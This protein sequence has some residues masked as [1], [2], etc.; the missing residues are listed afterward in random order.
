VDFQDLGN[1]LKRVKALSQ[2]TSL[3]PPAFRP[4]PTA[5][6]HALVVA[7][8][9]DGGLDATL[10]DWARR[11]PGRVLVSGDV[12]GTLRDS[13]G[14]RLSDATVQRMAVRARVRCAD[15]QQVHERLC[16]IIAHEAGRTR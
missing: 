9:N 1:A 11:C 12:L 16:A 4:Q 10:A 15:L 14:H 3:S 7:L 6:L 8:G 5:S 13:V 2:A